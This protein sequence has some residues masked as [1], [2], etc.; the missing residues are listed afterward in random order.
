MKKFIESSTGKETLCFSHYFRIKLV[1]IPVFQS[2]GIELYP[3]P[4]ATV[5]IIHPKISSF[6][7]QKSNKIFF[8]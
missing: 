1:M 6:S 3:S 5:E 2:Q 7:C 8:L 4:H